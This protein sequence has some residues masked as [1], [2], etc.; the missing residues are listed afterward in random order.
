[1]PGCVC[2]VGC[3]SWPSMNEF[4]SGTRS[5]KKPHTK[6]GVLFSSVRHACFTTHFLV[7]LCG[8]CPESLPSVMQLSPWIALH[9]G[10]EPRTTNDTAGTPTFPS[11]RGVDRSPDPHPKESDPLCQLTP[12]LN[13]ATFC[14]LPF[15]RHET[16]APFFS[17]FFLWALSALFSFFCCC[18]CSGISV[19]QLVV[20][21]PPFCFSSAIP[22]SVRRLPRLRIRALACLSSSRLPSLLRSPSLCPVLSCLC[23]LPRRHNRRAHTCHRLYANVCVCARAHAILRVCA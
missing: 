5:Q 21:S 15:L 12:T 4:R 22:P 1:M 23:S 16:Q 14:F 8:V 6:N 10:R 2:A 11:S 19:G 7:Y 20:F 13:A 9:L 18:C 17:L 3:V